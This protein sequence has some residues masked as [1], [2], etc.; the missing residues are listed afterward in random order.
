VHH[1]RRRSALGDD[2]QENL[3]T[4]CRRCHQQIHGHVAIDWQ[5]QRVE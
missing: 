4:L 1:Q 2:A 5:D 3:I